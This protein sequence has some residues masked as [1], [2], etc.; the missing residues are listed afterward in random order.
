MGLIPFLSPIS[1]VLQIKDKTSSMVCVP[2]II[3]PAV[4]WI[5][6]NYLRSYLEPILAPILGPILKP[7][8]ALVE[9][10][11]GKYVPN[12]DSPGAGGGAKCPVTGSSSSSTDATTCPGAESQTTPKVTKRKVKKAD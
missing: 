9:P 11:I 10:Y 7:L 2:C 3:I 4:I 8:Y 1:I 5:Y 6:Q 12:A